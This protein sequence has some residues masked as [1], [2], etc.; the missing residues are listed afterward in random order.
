MNHC[1]T[2]LLL[3]LSVL[4]LPALPGFAEPGPV[5]VEQITCGPGHH[6]YGYIGHVGNTPWNATDRHMVLLRTDFQDRMPRPD[7]AAEIM[8]LDTQSGNTLE[9]LDETRAWNFQQGSMLY[10]NPEAPEHQFFFNDR[11]PGTNGIF[12]VLY[13]VTQ[14]RRIR[15]Y[16]FP[17]SPVGNS[18]VAQRGGFF[19]AIN[20]GRLA[21]LR[22]VTGYP[23]A[24][25]WSQNSPQPEND[26]IWRVEV[27]SGQRTLVVSYHQ[28]AEALR[29]VRPDIAEYPLFINH[30]LCSRDS[31]QLYAFLRGGW[32]GDPRP[33]RIDAPLLFH[34]DTGKLTIPLE[35]VG[36][37][38]EWAPGNRLIGAKDGR[39][40][41][42]DP[43]QNTVLGTIGEPESLPTPG[44]DVAL[45]PDGQWLINGR[46]EGAG[47]RYTVFH[48]ES[49]QWFGTPRLE[50]G[51][52]KNGE[53]RIDPAPCWNRA[54]TAFSAPALASDGTRQTFVFRIEARL[55]ASP[56][57]P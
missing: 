1:Q 28:L 50:I 19:L 12:C 25:D 45:S 10:W 7:E 13:D 9:K 39:Q 31:S 32:E 40:V 17:D 44:G 22:P 15:E 43:R 33:K 24:W 20:Y 4:W 6:F 48:L 2:F 49:G 34:L 54:G 23:G 35:H 41:F 47:N 46:R 42:F 57:K 16:R 55:L 56:Q 29:P 26:G 11:D 27:A 8:L 38:P 51:P 52:Y 3:L 18:G 30:T 21:R 14:R 5:S 37:H 53:L 36:G